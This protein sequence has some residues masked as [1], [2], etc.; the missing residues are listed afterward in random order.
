M[1][2]GTHLLAELLQCSEEILDD[3][4]LIEKTLKKAAETAELQIV[5]VS[6]HRF[7]PQGI[8]S[9][10]I[11]KESHISIHT[12]P[13]YGYAAV[14]I[15]VCKGRPLKALRF[16]VGTFRPKQVKVTRIERG[17]GVEKKAISWSLAC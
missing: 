9:I 12:W 14:D 10:V 13:E 17:I 5:G 4:A 6:T 11:I 16:I 8:S 1:R 3:E 2:L 15:F 7:E